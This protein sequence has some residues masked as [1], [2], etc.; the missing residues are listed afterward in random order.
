[1]TTPLAGA[2]RDLAGAVAG[3]ERAVFAVSLPDGW[4][5]A[6]AE[7]ARGVRARLVDRGGGLLDRARRLSEVLADLAATAA[8]P[9][10]PADDARLATALA[11]AAGAGPSPAG[12]PVDGPAPAAVA[13][14]WAGLDPDERT[15]LTAGRPE[16]VGG[17]DGIPARDRDR[18]NRV[19]L[20]AARRAGEAE[21]AALDAARDR[22]GGFGDLQDVEERL[23]EVRARLGRLAAID[24]AGAGPGHGLLDLDPASG[25]AA[26]ATGDVDRARHVGV[27][28]PGFTA[29]AEDLP[30]RLVELDALAARAGPDAALVAWY[31]YD[32]PQWSGVADPARSVLG[33]RPAA[34]GAD[35]LASFLTG[36]DAARPGGPSATRGPAHVTAVGHSYG[37]LT[38]AQALPTARGVDDVVLLGSP[39]V[40]P[41]PQL[42][43]H[44]WVA[45]ARGDPVADAGWFGPD[46]NSSAA[47]RGLSTA[48]QPARTGASGAAIPAGRASHGHG[49]YL[50]PGTTSAEGVA[51][52]VGGRPE[53]AVL[54]RTVGAGDRLRAILGRDSAPEP[55]R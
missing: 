47:V 1:M 10:G 16:L 50:R 9:L 42:P 35:R 5:G 54:D 39:G 27:F 21:E 8:V 38:V 19:R 6:A 29:R 2:A 17:L 26:V 43:G 12:A 23:A 55:A 4:S 48:P 52:V 13:H 33:T 45:E 15:R 14:W 49:E 3:W 37:T 34:A 46:P 25:R 30:G 32:A 18:A 20:A 41:A 53:D 7:A 31:D 44:V 22:A 40:T 28:V 51:A 24:A 36:L 11:V